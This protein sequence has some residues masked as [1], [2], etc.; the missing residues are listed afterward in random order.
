[1]P[2]SSSVLRRNTKIYDRAST[3]QKNMSDGSNDESDQE[4]KYKS[5][6]KNVNIKYFIN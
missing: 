2:F 4:T 6:A 3:L 5:K 1:M